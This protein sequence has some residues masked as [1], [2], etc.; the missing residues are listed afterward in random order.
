VK[1]TPWKGIFLGSMVLVLLVLARCI[2][3]VARELYYGRDQW[4]DLILQDT[5]FYVGIAAVVVLYISAIVYIV[6]TRKT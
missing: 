1:K 4:M 2:A 6:R 5:W 3:T